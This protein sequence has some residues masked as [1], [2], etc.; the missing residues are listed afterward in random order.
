MLAR[1][2]FNDSESIET[3]GYV[4]E[5]INKYERP[6]ML[7]IIN[8]DVLDTHEMWTNREDFYTTISQEIMNRGLSAVATMLHENKIIT[9]TFV[10]GKI[11]S[12]VTKDVGKSN[13]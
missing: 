3:T 11:E 1:I 7:R 2:I 12:K 8:S 13:I 6:Y 4:D 5:L 9:I 10:R